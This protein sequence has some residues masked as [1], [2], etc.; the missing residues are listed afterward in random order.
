VTRAGALPQD[1]W[2]RHWDEYAGSAE[3]NPA[4][5][6]RRRVV[7]SLLAVGGGPANILDIGS[8][9]GDLIR[10]LR[11]RHPRAALCGIDYS[12]SGVEASALKVPS[13]RFVQRDLLQ[14]GTP[15]DG[16]AGWA[17]HA[18]CSE[19]LEHVD[20]PGVLLRNAR[21]YLAPG[22]RLVVTVPGGPMSAFDRHIGHRGHF[23]AA[24]L[25]GLLA[26]SGFEV[27]RTATAGFPFFNLY[28]LTVILRGERLVTDAAGGEGGAASPAARLAMA[29][30]RALFALN[31]P[32][33]PRGWQI[34]GVAR[35]PTLPQAPAE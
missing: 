18:V 25:H 28:R 24:R 11:A 5:L 23:S 4:Q 27:E 12:Q 29:V 9:Q 7:E 20:E 31:L 8:G 13:A 15:P 17:T 6:L 19:V 22:C 30:F 33:G 2:D 21:E 34:V 3:R 10:D 35:V 1:D 32:L 26:G 14:P 16:L